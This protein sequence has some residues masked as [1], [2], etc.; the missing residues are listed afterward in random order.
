MPSNT[1]IRLVENTSDRF[2]HDDVASVILRAAGSGPF[3]RGCMIVAQAL[4]QIYGGRIWVL[5]GRWSQQAE[6]AVLKVGDMFYDAAG[7]GALEGIIGRFSEAEGVNIQGA[8]PIEPGDLPDAS[9]SFLA[10]TE[11]AQLLRK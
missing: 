1:I 11:V 5:I 2:S 6:Y 8:R 7:A 9:R 10:A 3:D 4:Q